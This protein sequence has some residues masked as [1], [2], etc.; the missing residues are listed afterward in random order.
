MP[1]ASP[2]PRG[3]PGGRCCTTTRVTTGLL[4][5]GGDLLRDG[6]STQGPEGDGLG[7][8]DPLPFLGR[9]L[10]DGGTALGVGEVGP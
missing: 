9:R 8:D 3:R 1:R 2:P 6:A 7:F 10:G 5:G 4:R